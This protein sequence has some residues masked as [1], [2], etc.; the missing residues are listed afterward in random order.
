MS[1]LHFYI[2]DHYSFSFFVYLYISFVICLFVYVPLPL[3]SGWNM[4]EKKVLFC[5]IYKMDLKSPDGHMFL[6]N[7]RE[8]E[9]GN[10]SY[11]ENVLLFFFLSPS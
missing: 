10:R 9:G 11:L 2:L 5:V 4:L 8:N 3:V 6:R 1:P 7:T